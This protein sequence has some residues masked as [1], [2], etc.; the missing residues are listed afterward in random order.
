MRKATVQNSTRISSRAQR[1]TGL[2]ARLSLIT[3]GATQHNVLDR[4]GSR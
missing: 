3:S 1:K 2:D 4:F